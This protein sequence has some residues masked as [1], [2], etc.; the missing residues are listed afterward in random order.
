MQQ[1]EI[2]FCIDSLFNTF[3][4]VEHIIRSVLQI[5]LFAET[6]FKCLLIYNMAFEAD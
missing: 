3:L 4:D 6:K 2:F 5:V 1:L